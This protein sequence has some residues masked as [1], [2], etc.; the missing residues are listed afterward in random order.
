ME[1]VILD[2]WTKHMVC[3]CMNQSHI[4][5]GL[6]LKRGWSD[7]RRIKQLKRRRDILNISFFWGGSSTG[8][9]RDNQRHWNSFRR[10]FFFFFLLTRLYDFASVRQHVVTWRRADKKGGGE[11]THILYVRYIILLRSRRQ[12]E[13]RKEGNH[14]RDKRWRG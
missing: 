9:R 13:Q 5:C 10:F 3:I 7:G 2:Y 12:A 11:G 6:Q 1:C 4:D 14:T 8:D